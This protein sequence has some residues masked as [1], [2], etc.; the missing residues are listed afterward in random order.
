MV[1]E[2]GQCGNEDILTTVLMYDTPLDNYY[3]LWCLECIL[4]F[5]DPV[6]ADDA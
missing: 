4:E 6:E 3:E 1:G 2:C 5:A